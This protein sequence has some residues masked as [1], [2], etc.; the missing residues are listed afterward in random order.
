MHFSVQFPLTCPS[1]LLRPSHK[2]WCPLIM[3]SWL[4]SVAAEA[5]SWHHSKQTLMLFWRQ[6]QNLNVSYFYRVAFLWLR[7]KYSDSLLFKSNNFN[8]MLFSIVQFS[9]IF[10]DRVKKGHFLWASV[11]SESSFSASLGAFCL[12]GTTED[13]LKLWPRLKQVISGTH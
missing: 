10:M 3:S 12:K 5:T 11:V 8:H 13:W 2:H 6:K 9:W 4:W 1:S 7:L